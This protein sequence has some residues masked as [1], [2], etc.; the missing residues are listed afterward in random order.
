MLEGTDSTASSVTGQAAAPSGAVVRRRDRFLREWLP[1]S[2]FYSVVGCV[3]TWPL[4]TR[5]SNGFYGFG[6]DNWGGIWF[7]KW[8]HYTFWSG[9]PSHI[10]H[11]MEYPFGFVFDDRYIAPYDRFFAIV[12]GGIS[13]GL[14]AY[15]LMMLVSFPM[16]GISMYALARYLTHNRSASLLGGLIFTLSPFHLAMAMQYPAMAC[17][18][19]IPLL[20]LALVHALRTRR[21]RDAAWAGAALA[22]VW[23][24]SYYYGWFAIWFVLV[25][26]LTAGAIGFRHAARQRKFVSTLRTGMSF[27]ATRGAVMGA[28][29]LAIAVPL[30]W[31]L[32]NNVLSHSSEYARQRNDLP[33]TAVR[34]WMYIL[35]P[36]DNPVFGSLT[37][38]KIQRFLGI[39]PVYEQ[40]VYLG[41]VAV[42]FA[43]IALLF[44]RRAS[45][46]FR[47]AVFPLLAGAVF[48]GLLTLGPIIPL[49]V[50]S[51]QAWLT[52]NLYRHV[53]GPNSLLFDLSQNFRYY[54]R[55]FI[56]VSVV[57]ASLAAVGFALASR[58]LKAR[59]GRRGPQVLLML[60]MAGVVL[61]FSNLPPQHFVD[62]SAPPWLAAVKAL[63]QNAKIM[64]YPDATYSSPR[65]LQYVYWQTREG[66]TTVNPPNTPQ[67]QAFMS[68]L[69]NPNSFLSGKRLSRVGVDFVVVHTH[70]AS[71]TF[72][73]YQP[74][75]PSDQLPRSAGRANPWFAFYRSTS[76]AVIYRVRRAPS[77]TKG[78]FIGF[79]AG[80]GALEVDPTGH[81]RWMTDSNGTGA[82]FVFAAR[83]YK[84]AVFKVDLTSFYEPRIITVLF[85]GK[86]IVRRKLTPA[87]ISRVSV[88]VRLRKGLHT[89]RLIATPGP[90]V[91]NDVLHNNDLRSVS[92]R[93]GQLRIR[94][95]GQ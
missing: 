77:V 25:A 95:S 17:I 8:I 70:L 63:P 28:T 82:M 22:L 60:A 23:A 37:R 16:A 32:I 55:A 49:N 29:F 30:L 31:S 42:A 83:D 91:I 46:V 75:W 61:E 45:R 93:A 7:I 88:P 40:S 58:P 89:I 3:F 64:E 92:V 21:L 54:G 20:V 48:C 73:P 39:L 36:H 68:S 85:D 35:P 81:W 86:R 74:A 19:P 27:V 59:F 78:A 47:N 67:S 26:L 15:N 11:Q 62:L 13:N 38:D 44:Y 84:R 9:T 52:P 90:V 57:L 51:V 5:M 94:L 4:V 76:D 79:D 18:F 1:V 69:D 34:P 72:P 10:S 80:W 66:H 43:L 24:T 2:L 53:T 65:S 14:F 56:Y 41:A 12:F 87:E 6:N 33:F 50:F 71:P